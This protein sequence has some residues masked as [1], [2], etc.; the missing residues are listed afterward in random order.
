MSKTFWIGL[1]VLVLGIA[2]ALAGPS[3]IHNR[4]TYGVGNT[5]VTVTDHNGIPSWVGWIIAAVGLVL[6]LSGIR[7]DDTKVSVVRDT[8]VRDT[9]IHEDHT[10][11]TP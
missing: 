11:H 9:V 7:R 4:D 5:S 1:V 3:F 2:V 6:V 8:V 10:P